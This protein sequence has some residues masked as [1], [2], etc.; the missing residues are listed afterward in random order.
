VIPR[1]FDRY[2]ALES[3]LTTL[4][5]KVD[6]ATLKDRVDRLETA[7][8]PAAGVGAPAGLGAAAGAAPT[9]P[10]APTQGPKP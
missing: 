4:A 8:K 7:A 1:Y 6:V 9:P 5:A 10:P 3:G 2:Y